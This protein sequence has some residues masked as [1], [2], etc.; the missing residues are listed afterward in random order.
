MKDKTSH[1][2]DIA[3]FALACLYFIGTRTF[4]R[5]CL[6]PMENGMWMT[7]H[8]AGQALSGLACVLAVTAAMRLLIKSGSVRLDGCCV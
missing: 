2:F 1:L 6:N 7:C 5:P 3:L 4:L 8:W